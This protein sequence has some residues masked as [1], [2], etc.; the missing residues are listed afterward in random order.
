MDERDYIIFKDRKE[1]GQ[2]LSKKLS[3]YK[4]KRN[5]IVLG[6]PRGGVVVAREI[7]DKLKIPLDVVVTK[8]IGAPHQEELAIGAVGPE[9]ALILDTKLI[10]ELGVSKDYIKYK[11][12][13]KTD[14]VVERLLKFR[15]N[16]SLRLVGKTVVLVDDGIA[17]GAS[18]EVAIKFLKTKNVKKIVLSVPVAP[19]EAVSKFKKI[20]DELV[21]LESP[22]LFQAVGQF[23]I[24]FPQIT[25]EEVIEMLN[26]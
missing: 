24:N 22:L 4:K 20:V 23:Y 15:K 10:N 2:L 12:R 14:E 17:T 16:E 7:S 3:K 8:K 1:A 26:K 25:D 21:V 13:E 9:G 11:A 5:V 6:I 18:V 19:K